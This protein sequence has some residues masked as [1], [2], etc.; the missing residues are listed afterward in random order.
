MSHQ[1]GKHKKSCLWCFCWKIVEKQTRFI[2]NK[3]FWTMKANKEL[4]RKLYGRGYSKIKRELMNK[5]SE[6]P[7]FDSEEY[8]RVEKERF[9]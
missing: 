4:L 6:C 1:V 2:C 3:L 9:R 7:Y 5:A 8:P